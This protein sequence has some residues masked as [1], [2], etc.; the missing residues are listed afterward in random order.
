MAALKKRYLVD[1]SA[2]ARMPQEPVLSVISIV[3]G[4]GQDSG[5]AA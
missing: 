3:E 2:L 1:K 4:L 5:Q